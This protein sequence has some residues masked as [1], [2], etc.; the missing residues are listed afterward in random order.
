MTDNTNTPNKGIKEIWGTILPDLINEIQNAENNSY[1]INLLEEVKMANKDVRKQNEGNEEKSSLDVNVNE[2]ANSRILAKLFQYKSPDGKYEILQS[3]LDYISKEKSVD[4]NGENGI[5]DINNTIITTEETLRQDTGNIKNDNSKT[6][7]TTENTPK[8]ENGRIDIL[9][10]TGDYA[11]I[12]ENKLFN[13]PDQEHQLAGY[14]EKVKGVKQNGESKYKD[15]NIFVIYLSRKGDE[16]DNGSWES[17]T[18]TNF[19]YSESFADRYANIS[20]REDI[21]PWLKDYVL[22]NVRKK[23][24]DLESALVQYIN[25]LKLE[26]MKNNDVSTEW[27]GKKLK[28]EGENREPDYMVKIHCLEKVEGLIDFLNS[29][30]ERKKFQKKNKITGQKLEKLRDFI[31]EHINNK[32][33]DQQETNDLQ[34]I[35]NLL[36]NT[37]PQEGTDLL[38]KTIAVI[39]NL[40]DDCRDK[41][42]EPFYRVSKSYFDIVHVSS[43]SA[44]YCW[45]LKNKKW[46]GEIRF[47]WNPFFFNDKNEYKLTL[48]INLTKDAKVNGNR[49][50]KFNTVQ[51][52]IKQFNVPNSTIEG[53]R[54]EVKNVKQ[55]STRVQKLLQINLITNEKLLS[56]DPEHQETLFRAI[57]GSLSGVIDAIDNCFSKSC[58]KT[59]VIPLQ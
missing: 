21:L 38:N 46:E 5:I 27:L 19:S 51:E 35:K 42:L 12:F 45:L 4:F 18:V 39:E 1:S 8:Q 13:A 33:K 23:D 16:P 31:I 26:F 50:N 2:N 59:Q 14:I 6:N 53:V 36:E 55:E 57:Y 17:S 56:F 37:D 20:F 48:E 52:A 22:P 47:F 49:I 30:S 9:V 7:N 29:D 44:A 58:I 28:G 25:Y 54:I 10:R 24:T 34:K 32:I 15:N 3:L 41:V 11:I 40:R 43:Q